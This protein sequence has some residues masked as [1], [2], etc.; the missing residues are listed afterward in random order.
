MHVMGL[1]GSRV[2][3]RGA[4]AGPALGFW[5]DRSRLFPLL[6][7]GVGPLV[8]VY[9]TRAAPR[10]ARTEVAG[11]NAAPVIEGPGR[12]AGDRR[13]RGVGDLSVARWRRTRP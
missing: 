3:A 6:A 11:K 7:A 10:A 2:A 8:F 1:V 13:H 12:G 4:L 5:L 9:D